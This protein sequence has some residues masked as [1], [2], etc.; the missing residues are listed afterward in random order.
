MK[1]GEFLIKKKYIS[2]DQLGEALNL[3]SDNKYALLG[4][5]LV[6]LGIL[7]KKEVLKFIEEYIVET[8]VV[9]PKKNE[10]LSQNEID[11][12]IKKLQ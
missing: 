2:E 12:L 4:D 5:V 6:T 11:D 10:W 1:I 8:G 9:V 3:Q 7:T